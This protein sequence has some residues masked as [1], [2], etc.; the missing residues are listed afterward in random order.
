MLSFLALIRVSWTV[1]PDA[2]G[3]IICRLMCL[4]K[5][6]MTRHRVDATMLTWRVYK[7]PL[8]NQSGLR[9]TSSLLR[10]AIGRGC[11]KLAFDIFSWAGLLFPDSTK[12]P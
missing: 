2:S 6:N 7:K 12:T 9:H 8:C 4:R 3:T 5:H 11:V 10:T 1:I